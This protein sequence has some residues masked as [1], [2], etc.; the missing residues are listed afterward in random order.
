MDVSGSIFV[1]WHRLKQDV[2]GGSLGCN[3]FKINNFVD[4]LVYF[5]CVRI[6][7]FTNFTFESLPIK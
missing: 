7:L 4:F 5:E 3:F 1:Q 6:H 2:V